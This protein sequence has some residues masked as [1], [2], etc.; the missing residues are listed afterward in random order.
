MSYT[1]EDEETRACKEKQ[2]E[3]LKEE[4]RRK[5]MNAA[6]KHFPTTE[7]HGCSATSW[8]GIPL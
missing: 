8:G 5:L 4:I 7:I 6:G 2:V 3:D 1:P